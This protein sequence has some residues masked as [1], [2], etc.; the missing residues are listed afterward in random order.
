LSQHEL[1]FIKLKLASF[2]VAHSVFYRATRV[3]RIVSTVIEMQC[4]SQ[5]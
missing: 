2:Y 1:N 5:H 4:P 3:H